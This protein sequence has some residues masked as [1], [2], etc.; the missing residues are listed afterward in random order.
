MGFFSFGADITKC[1]DCGI[2]FS[3]SE[4]INKHRDK[5]HKKNKEKCRF[6]GA[7]FNY[8]EALRKHKKKCK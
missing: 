5:A 6:C 2:E 4:S 8:P 7:E 3:D 1:K